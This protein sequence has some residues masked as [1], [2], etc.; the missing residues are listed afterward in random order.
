VAERLPPLFTRPRS[1]ACLLAKTPLWIRE[2][3]NAALGSHREPNLVM[4]ADHSPLA[5]R[6]CSSCAQPM[7]LARR[8]QRFGGLPDLCT[9]ECPA[10]GLSHT[11]ECRP[12]IRHAADV[13]RKQAKACRELAIQAR[14]EDRK[15][16]LRLSEGWLKLAQDDD[17]RVR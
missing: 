1:T 4:S 10:C 8:T 2:L 11:E 3:L 15:F 7:K 5:S 13:Y 9:F 14:R 16:W 12:A 6:R 17:E